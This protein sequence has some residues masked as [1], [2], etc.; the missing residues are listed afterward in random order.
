MVWVPSIPRRVLPKSQLHGWIN[1]TQ[2][3][4]HCRIQYRRSRN[5]HKPYFITHLTS[6]RLE[7]EKQVRLNAAQTEK[8]WKDIGKEVGR[9][10]WRIEN[11]RTFF[12]LIFSPILPLSEFDRYHPSRSKNLR[13]FLRWRFVYPFEYIQKTKRAKAVSRR[14]FLAWVGDESR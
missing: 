9:L 4:R 8:A 5:R 12:L 6:S 3:H 13:N 11:F 7:L 10:I 2:N 1:Q 14:A